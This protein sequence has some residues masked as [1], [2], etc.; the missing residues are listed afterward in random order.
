MCVC[1]TFKNNSVL[2]GSI[3]TEKNDFPDDMCG[4]WAEQQNIKSRER[5]HLLRGRYLQ[6]AH[7]SNVTL[8]EIR[9]HRFLYF[10]GMDSPG[11]TIITAQ[12]RNIKVWVGLSIDNQCL[13]CEL[14]SST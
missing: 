7:L 9:K 12:D 5:T 6:L 2:P 8:P 13:I 14:V 11:G 3:V 4:R 10:P 1:V